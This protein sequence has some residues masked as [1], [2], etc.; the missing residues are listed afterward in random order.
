MREGF[1]LVRER[2]YEVQHYCCGACLGDPSSSDGQCG[3]LRLGRT[4]DV[5]V[6][7]PQFVVGRGMGMTVISSVPRTEPGE[8]SAF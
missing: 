8:H 7:L 5:R 3:L 6:E 4:A 2:L 1:L